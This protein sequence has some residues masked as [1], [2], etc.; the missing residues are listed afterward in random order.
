[1]IFVYRLLW[2]IALALAFHVLGTLALAGSLKWRNR[3][4]FGFTSVCA[5]LVDP[6]DSERR[7]IWAHAAS[8]GEVKALSVFV[9]EALSRNARLRFVVSVMTDAGYSTA[10]DSL[11]DLRDSGALVVCFLPLDCVWPVNAALNRIK[12]S[13]FIFTETEIWPN[14]ALTLGSRSIPTAIINGRISEKSFQSYN[15]FSAR[16]HDVFQSYRMILAQSEPD[17]ERFIRLGAAKENVFVCGNLKA[18]IQGAR[19]T[20]RER[21]ELRRGLGVSEDE[22]LLV[23]GSVRPGEEA[24]IIEA[25]KSVE[26]DCPRLRL[27]LAL[28]HLDRLTEIRRLI[29]DAGLKVSAYSEKTGDNSAVIVID[30]FGELTKLYGAADLA[31]VGGTLAPIGGHNILE[32][33]QAGTPVIFGPFTANVREAAQMIIERKLGA[34]VA[35]WHEFQTLLREAL[36]GVVRFERLQPS[37]PVPDRN[38]A[39]ALTMERLAPLL[40]ASRE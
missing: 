33:P 18:D 8:A 34:Q 4:G 29:R 38:S 12:P 19:L 37:S 35:D 3:L 14:W 7:T 10:M 31:F 40:G 2:I 15:R 5:A 23:G 27:A 36:S 32:P 6:V 21:S 17:A 39:I 9:R 26:R 16:L 28:R 11:G 22:F 24:G 20:A 30:T 13:L 25:Y 1:M